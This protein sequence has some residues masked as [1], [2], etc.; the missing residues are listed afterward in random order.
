M[1]FFAL[2]IIGA[3]VCLHDNAISMWGHA[4]GLTGNPAQPKS[5]PVLPHTVVQINRRVLL[6]PSYPSFP[7]MWSSLSENGSSTWSSSDERGENRSQSSASSFSC[8]DNDMIL[9]LGILYDTQQLL[10]V[11][12]KLM[13]LWLT[14]GCENETVQ[15]LILDH[16]HNL[17]GYLVRRDAGPSAKAKLVVA[18]KYMQ[19]L[20]ASTAAYG[21]VGE[22]FVLDI[23]G[24]LDLLK[25][26]ELTT[27]AVSTIH[28]FFQNLMRAEARLP[29][30]NTKVTI[31]RELLNQSDS[32]LG[33]LNEVALYILA[34][35]LV[36]CSV[37]DGI[38][39]LVTFLE[40]H[41]HALQPDFANVEHLYSQVPKH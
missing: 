6:T 25:A 30:P 19:L 13:E 16:L 9:S 38:R 20:Q 2:W 41:E 8:I 4:S 26:R 7:E 11:L 40:Q 23:I 3:A 1:A 5:L 39:R 28:D 15:R 17:K 34:D 12:A 10:G 22:E 31:L 27:V 14:M 24:V 35:F 18:Q 21:G 29:E 32:S 37:E 33:S 36:S